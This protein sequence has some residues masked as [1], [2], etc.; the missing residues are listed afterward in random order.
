MIQELRR[1]GEQFPLA[2]YRVPF[3]K[4]AQR[5]AG[6]HVTIVTWGWASWQSIA[7]AD[8]VA[9]AHGI[10]AEVLDLRTLKPYDRDAVVASAQ[11]TGRV[12]VVQSDRTYAGY[13]RQI[14]GDLVETMEGVTV[15]VV[16]QL[17][18]PAV[19]Q[20]RVLEDAITLQEAD[21]EA[22]IVDIAKANPGAW[23][24]NELHWLNHSPSRH[25]V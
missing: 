12:L 14:Q 19:G 25:L 17:N 16:G 8:R 22:A 15:R 21:I 10:E 9:R 7:A 3:G 5:R 11:R 4:A 1:S 6:S 20:S 18:T 13:G 2:D 24:E 23:L